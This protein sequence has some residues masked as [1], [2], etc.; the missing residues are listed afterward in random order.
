MGDRLELQFDARKRRLS[1]AA[2][3]LSNCERR[4]NVFDQVDQVVNPMV[5]NAV[6]LGW[7]KAEVSVKPQH[8]PRVD[9]RAAFDAALD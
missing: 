1:T 5:A 6:G 7:K 9:D 3:S 4:P 8:I 2:A